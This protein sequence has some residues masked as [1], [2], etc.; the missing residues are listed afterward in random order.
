[1]PIYMKFEGAKP[2]VPGTVKDSGHAN[3]VEV[4]SVQQGVH[5][6]ISNFGGGVERGSGSMRPRDVVFTMP[7]NASATAVWSN[8]LEGTLMKVLVDFLGSGEKKG[9]VNLS[10]TL[11]K[12]IVASVSVSGDEAGPDKS[13]MVATLN[14]EQMTY[15]TK[16]KAAGAP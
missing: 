9:E 10:V 3:W 14:F 11:T 1:M 13:V 16:G 2:A 8:S 6:A 5:K 15:E 12:A 7:M 4:T